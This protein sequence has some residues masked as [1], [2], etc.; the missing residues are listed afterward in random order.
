MDS[1]NGHVAV[2]A[3]GHMDVIVD[4]LNQ[5]HRLG[6]LLL[7]ERRSLLHLLALGQGAG[8]DAVE[9]TNASSK[10]APIWQGLSAHCEVANSANSKYIQPQLGHFVW[11]ATAFCGR[12]RL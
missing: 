1:Q 5:R 2:L 4:A 10:N 9:E 12:R 8:A 6:G 7:Q 11:T 3:H